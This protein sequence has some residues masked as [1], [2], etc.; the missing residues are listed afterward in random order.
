MNNSVGTNE[1]ALLQQ[2]DEELRFKEFLRILSQ[3]DKRCLAELLGK[4]AGR[5]SELDSQIEN[6]DRKIIQ[7]KTSRSNRNYN[8]TQVAHL[9]K[10]HRQTLYYW[11]KKNWFKPKRDYR[12]YPIFTVL[13]IENLVKWRNSVK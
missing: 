4:G 2:S 3:A 7:R 10:V 8:L 11:I 1:K 12:D 6:C 5:I 9:L 13:D